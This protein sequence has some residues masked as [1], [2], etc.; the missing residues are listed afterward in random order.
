MFKM[1]KVFFRRPN[2]HIYHYICADLSA[3]TVQNIVNKGV[4][5]FSL[6]VEVIR[7]FR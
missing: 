6:L 1:T 4:N 2:R 3:W 7:E 5:L